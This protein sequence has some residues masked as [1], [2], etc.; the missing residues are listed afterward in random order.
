ML[1]NF[2]KKLGVYTLIYLYVIAIQ[3]F[4][5]ANAQTIS[6]TALP[7]DGIV[8]SGSANISQ[9]N[10]TLNVNQSTNNAIISWNTFDIG[11]QATVNFNQPSSASNT[12]NRVRSTDPSRIY[13]TLNATGNIFFINPSGVLIG[14]SGRINVG[15]LV[16]STMDMASNDFNNQNYNFSTSKKSSIV[17][18]GSINSK[19]V[20]LISTDV[21]NY[22]SISAKSGSAALV[23][24]SN[25]KLSIST[26]GKIVVKISESDLAN[27]IQNG[28]TIN[29]D[30]G[31]VLIKSSAAQSLVKATIKGPSGKRKLISDNG[32]LKLVSN[33][34]TIK[35]KSVKID[36]GKNG[37][38]DNS[39]TI[40]VSSSTGKA[41][42]VEVT[43]KEIS[44]NSGSKILAKGKNGGGD[45]LIGGDWKGSG[46]LLQA[47]YT[48]VEKNTL[49]DA[50]STGKGDGGK[51]VVWSDIKNSKSKTSA[52]GT[53]T[54]SAVDGDGGKIETSGATVNTNNIKVNAGSENGKGGLWL[55]DP[56]DYTIGAREASSISST[57]NSGTSVT[58]LTSAQNVS[59][60]AGLTSQANGDITVNSSITTTSKSDVTLTLTAA[61]DLTIGNTES[62]TKI[63]DTGAGK[64]N[65][66]LNSPRDMTIHSSIDVAG[67]VKLTTSGYTGSA[68]T[69]STTYSY[70]GAVQTYTASKY[71]TALT[72]DGYGAGGGESYSGK[73]STYRPGLGGRVQ[74]TL[75]NISAGDT[76]SIYV[77]GAGAQGK[78][79][80]S[81]KTSGGGA[82]GW[83]GG[84]QGGHADAGGGG[85]GATDIRLGGTALADRILVAGGGGG[86]GGEHRGGTGGDGGNT[87]GKDGSNDH[88][89]GGPYG[90]K[91]GTQAAG[92]AG[93]VAYQTG[94]GSAGVLG[95]GGKGGT[96]THSC[97]CYDGGGGGGGG[98]Y[99][100]GGGGASDG[101]SVNGQAM[102]GDAA[103]GGGG[104]SFTNTKYLAE[105][106]HTQGYSSASGNGSLKLTSTINTT[107]KGDITIGSN[108]IKSGSLSV[109]SNGNLALSSNISLLKT[110]YSVAGTKSGQGTVSY[111]EPAVLLLP[112]ANTNTNTKK[113]EKVAP[114]LPPKIKINR[115]DIAKFEPVKFKEIRTKLD[116]KNPANNN[117][118]PAG[119]PMNPAGNP[120]N[121]AG[122]PAGNPGTMGSFGNVTPGSFKPVISMKTPAMA[123]FKAV[124]FKGNSTG[125]K[126]N[127]KPM[128]GT[129]MASF[130]PVAFKVSN[131]AS[132]KV[133]PFKPVSFGS[134]GINFKIPQKNIQVPSATTKVNIDVKLK[135]G[136]Q[137]PSWVKFD[138]QTLQISGKP[139]EGFSGS[140]ELNLV[141][142]SE[143]GT[144]QVQDI[145]FD[146]NN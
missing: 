49:I 80:G 4:S 129:K 136:A 103:G 61:R 19:Y 89:G 93:G 82:G 116:P 26:D 97:K 30:N 21:S 106:T 124:K 112:A 90:G 138:P 54:A 53:L 34:G 131:N 113:A 126:S 96:Q 107:G 84:G 111:T 121:P 31:Q 119:N 51:I 118:N 120:M 68:S 38:V 36:A 114:K 88:S 92:G 13:G 33:N 43:G 69:S 1:K 44:I 17:N 140:L 8:K 62:T 72:V 5:F 109:T 71:L 83:N 137:L 47:T 67:S 27:L 95:I 48:T 76:L 81:N 77:G 25:A 85:G 56:Y 123:K 18:Y 3:F 28:G 130:K 7:T 35:G 57:L 105:A 139:P 102:Y 141:A 22:G 2:L 14:K 86:R 63:T 42:S 65:L 40:N 134:T 91:G 122:N 41:G 16:A 87:T 64:L 29:S 108:A 101:Y 24:G 37:L 66:A 12:L 117:L 133:V 143:D 110:D 70:T 60:G 78:R 115:F 73:Y 79:V 32:V 15:G 128:A 55:V 104:S 9:Q 20:A 46:D 132:F 10:N 52:N 146:I 99:G 74:A 144:Q 135:G 59:Y 58:I 94:A 23:S 127:F 142:T 6:S 11:S 45:V 50:S 75:Q 98:Y 39:G 100:G 125:I 145:Q